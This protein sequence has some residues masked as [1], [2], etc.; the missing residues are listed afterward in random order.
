MYKR[1][2]QKWITDI[3]ADDKRKRIGLNRWIN[4]VG[5]MEIEDTSALE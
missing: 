1:Y 3:L 2:V 4:D 5:M